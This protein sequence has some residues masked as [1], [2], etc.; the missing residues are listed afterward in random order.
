L[1]NEAKRV[2]ISYAWDDDDY[3]LWVRQLAIRLRNDGVDVRLDYWHLQETDTIAEFMNREVRHADWVLVLCSPSYQSKVHLSEDGERSTGVG[4]ESRLLGSSK[5][6]TSQN[7]ALAALG[8]GS[9]L[10]SAPDF[11]VGQVYCDL[12]NEATFEANYKTLLKRITGTSEKA[13]PVGALPAN[14]EETPLAPLRGKDAPA[15]G[16]LDTEVHFMVRGAGTEGRWTVELRTAG[17]EPVSAPFELD[18]APEGQTA[19]DLEA[20]TKNTCTLADI[21]NLGSELWSRLLGGPLEKAWDQ[22]RRQCRLRE[23]SILKVRLSLPP[24]LESLPWE[25]VWDFDESSLATSPVATFV[26]SPAAQELPPHR[27]A[28]GAPLKMLVVIPEGSGLR[29]SSE[30]EKIRQSALA[31]GDRV[32]IQSLDGKVTLDR[33]AKA[34]RET[35]DIVHFIGHG[36]LDAQGRGE[37]RLNRESPAE[38]ADSGVKSDGADWTSADLFARQFLRNPAQLVAVNC[39]HAG[40]IDP[41]ALSSLGGSLA[42]ARIPAVLLMRY[43]IHD[44]AAADFSAAFYRELFSGAQPGRVDLATQEGRA[45]LERTYRDGDRVRSAIAPAL[46]LAAG[47]EQ[48]FVLPALAKPKPQDGVS[49]V[50]VIDERIDR[51]LVRAIERRCCLPILGPGIL[52]AG[53]QRGDQVP[54]SPAGLA[55]KLAELSQF[56]GR[57]RIT[58]LTESM[59]DWLMPV[60][61]ERVCQHFESTADGERHDLV[62]AVQEV[63]RDLVSTAALRQIASWNVPGV[64]Y[65]YIDGLLEKSLQGQPGRNLRVVQS[66]ELREGMLPGNGELLLMNLRGSYMTPSSMVLTEQDQDRLLDRM[67][68]ISSFV[69]DLMNRIEGCNLLFLG[70]S[71]RDPLV[72]ALA[73]RLLR[74]DVARYRGTAFFICDHTTAADRAYWHQFMRLEWIEL[75][76]DTVVAGLTAAG[77]SA[78][79]PKSPS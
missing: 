71:A 79:R 62:E 51:R 14:L 40:G 73:R 44:S 41:Q 23:G 4:W 78:T 76:L 22:V 65:S 15:P 33:L 53:A 29:T 68:V 34:L 56:P 10:D 19:R 31:A 25:A 32:K 75:D 16:A 36:Q 37:L 67:G 57:E 45:T 17:S 11:L 64:V 52:A 38:E 27:S 2:F 35:W 20:I 59:A 1:P 46:Y 18:L 30:W 60:V 12:S 61:F 43:A 63:Y 70:V 6:M 72:R 55:Q 74:E 54:P 77:R 9:W 21:K 24:Q 3:K 42:R 50:T 28:G 13:P 69:A 66:E 26:R 39:C 8:R 58:P 47:C 5:F 48:L 7:K 49:L